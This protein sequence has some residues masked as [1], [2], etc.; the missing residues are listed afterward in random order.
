M[1]TVS[2]YGDASGQTQPEA[3]AA[4]FGGKPRSKDRPAHFGSH[5]FAV[6]GHVHDHL[7]ADAVRTNLN[8]PLLVCLLYTS[9]AADE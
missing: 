3:P 7:V 6:V 1:A 2:L 9:D 8:P 4:L 5:A